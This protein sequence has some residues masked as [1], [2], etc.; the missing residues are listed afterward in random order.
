MYAL[1]GLSLFWKNAM[2]EHTYEEIRSAVLDILVGR[3]QV[4]SP[5][6][7]YEELF[8]SVSQVLAYRDGHQVSIGAVPGGYILAGEEAETFREIFWDLFRPRHY[9]SWDRRGKCEFPLLSSVSI[10]QASYWSKMICIS[11]TMYQAIRK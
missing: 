7:Q 6:K 4:S 2:K 3:Q 9:H 5:N 10:W 1:M 11:S 8:R